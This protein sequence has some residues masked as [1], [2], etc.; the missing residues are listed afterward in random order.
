MDADRLRRGLETLSATAADRL[1]ER[2][3]EAAAVLAG[4]DYPGDPRTGVLT[5]GDTLFGP[6]FR[7][8]PCPVLDLESGACLLYEYRPI[9]CRTYGPAVTLEGRTLP[10]C[11]LNYTGLSPDQIEQLRVTIDP[12]EATHRAVEEFAANGGVEAETTIAFAFAT[13]S[14]TC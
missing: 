8:V 11:P 14:A 2:A 1:R 9:A 5:H 6:R 13:I 3:R 10:H 4:L 7:N 12:G